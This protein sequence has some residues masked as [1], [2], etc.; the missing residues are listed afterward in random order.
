MMGNVTVRT[1]I[2]HVCVFKFIRLFQK[3]IKHLFASY[4]KVSVQKVNPRCY[5][6]VNL[7]W[8]RTK[9]GNIKV[10]IFF[11]VASLPKLLTLVKS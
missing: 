6:A 11:T 5:N 9:A 8:P 3:I 1:L 10:E 2:L 4:R 7:L